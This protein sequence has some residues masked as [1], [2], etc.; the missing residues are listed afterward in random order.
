MILFPMALSYPES[1]SAVQRNGTVPFSPKNQNRSIGRLSIPPAL[2]LSYP[3]SD[4]AVQ[5]TAA[6]SHGNGGQ[7]RPCKRS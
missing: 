2:A 3:E 1:D 5:R 7:V 6:D 4:S